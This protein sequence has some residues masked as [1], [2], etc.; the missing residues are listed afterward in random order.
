[1]GT[2]ADWSLSKSFSLRL[3][4]KYN[5]TMTSLD[6]LNGLSTGVGFAVGSLNIDYAFVSYGDL[7]YTHRVSLLAKL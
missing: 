2:G 1:M 7:G 5:S 6:G 3:G 4:Y